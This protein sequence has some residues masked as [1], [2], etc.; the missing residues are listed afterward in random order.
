MSRRMQSFIKKYGPIEGPARVKYI[1]KVAVQ[2]R[3]KAYYR[4][5]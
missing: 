5:R 2:A 3:W 4:D 1:A